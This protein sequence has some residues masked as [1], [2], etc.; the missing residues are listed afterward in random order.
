MLAFFILFNVFIF[1]FPAPPCFH[2]HIHDHIL[3]KEKYEKII[4]KKQ[5]SG[6]PEDIQSAIPLL[7]VP[8]SLLRPDPRVVMTSYALPSPPPPAHPATQP[9]RPHNDVSFVC[10]LDELRRVVVNQ[11]HPPLP[12]LLNFF[13]RVFGERHYNFS[14]KLKTSFSVITGKNETRV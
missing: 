9:F 14:W 12:L 2:S 1:S 13:F 11:L 10:C 5:R 7:R 8:A 6:N 3:I 4:R